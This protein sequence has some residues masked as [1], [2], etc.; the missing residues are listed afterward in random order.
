MPLIEFLIYQ[1][2]KTLEDQA[3][4]DDNGEL[5]LNIYGSEFCLKLLR[6]YTAK[7]NVDLRFIHI[8]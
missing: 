1:L 8:H 5:R 2:K 4:G 7:T 3:I 6:N